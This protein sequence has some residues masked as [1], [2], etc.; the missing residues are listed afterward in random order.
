M[1]LNLRRGLEAPLPPINPRGTPPSSQPKTSGLLA[2]HSESQ[3]LE[4]YLLPPMETAAV[5]LRSLY[6]AIRKQLVDE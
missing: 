3:A 6:A 5:S 4:M 2:G 1:I